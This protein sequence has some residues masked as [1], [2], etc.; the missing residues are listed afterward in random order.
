[1]TPTLVSTFTCSGRTPLMITVMPRACNSVD[2]WRMCGHRLRRACRVETC[3]CHRRGARVIGVDDGARNTFGNTE[4]HRSRQILAH[5]AAAP[6]HVAQREEERRDG[7][8][9]MVA[10]EMPTFSAT[11]Q[12]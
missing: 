6:R 8:S 9:P 7:S 12:F 3:G 11:V 2:I 4:G 5:G 10:T 1:M